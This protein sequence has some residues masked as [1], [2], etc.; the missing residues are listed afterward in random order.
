VGSG[1]YKWHSHITG[2]VIKLE[3]LDKH[4]WAGVPTFKYV[5]Y[6]SIPE[7]STRLA[8]LET[9]EGDITRIGRPMVKKMLDAGLKVI[10]KENAAVINFN[11]NMIWT[12]PVFQDVRFRKALDLAIDKDSIIKHIFAGL[13]KRYAVYPG[14]NAFA[15]GA[16]P[17]LKPRH[18]Y[19][20]VRSDPP[21]LC[22][23]TRG[24]D[25]RLQPQPIQ[26]QR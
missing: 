26:L 9:G 14:R 18:L 3:A 7:E 15:C 2:S 19:R 11:A 10:T 4:W 24:Q 6:L 13:A 12:N 25:S 20:S 22:Q 21:T 17:A 5:S 23:D 8:M 1:P 16:D